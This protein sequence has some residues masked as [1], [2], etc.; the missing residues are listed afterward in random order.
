MLALESN[1][2]YHHLSP[3]ASVY[4][5]IAAETEYS[6]TCTRELRTWNKSGVEAMEECVTIFLVSLTFFGTALEPF[7][8]KLP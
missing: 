6:C 2:S 1:A 8:T 5:S 4:Q 3:R 7:S